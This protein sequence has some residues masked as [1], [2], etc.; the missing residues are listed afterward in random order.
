MTTAMVYAYISR[1]DS[2]KAVIE[3]T[4]VAVA[5][6]AALAEERLSPQRIRDE[7]DALTLSQ[8]LSALSYYYDHQREIGITILLEAHQIG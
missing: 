1:K 3:G 4:R 7:Y 8:V 6:L 2:G 5:D